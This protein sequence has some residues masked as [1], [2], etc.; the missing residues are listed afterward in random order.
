VTG[1]IGWYLGDLGDLP[2]KVIR[3][4]SCQVSLR[5]SHVFREGSFSLSAV[6]DQAQA[7]LPRVYSSPR[8]F[9]KETAVRIA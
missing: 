8:S 4:F 2:M 9:L 5:S 7:T 3:L 6:S 1:Y